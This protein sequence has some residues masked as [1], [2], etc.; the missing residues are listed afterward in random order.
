MWHSCVDSQLLRYSRDCAQALLG[1]EAPQALA[2]SQRA[3]QQAATAVALLGRPRGD[4]IVSSAW[5]HAIGESPSI[6][7]TGFRP[8]D[9]AVYLL[10]EG[11]PTPVVNLVAHQGQARLIAPAFDAV[12]RLALF[13]RIQGWPSDILD[14]AI[15]LSL[16][17]DMDPNPE[18]CL[19]LAAK[20]M[21]ATLRITARDRA[22]R[23]RRLRR[24]VDRVSAATIAARS[25]AHSAT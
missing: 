24:A 10:A 13:E 22:E 5:L 4:V 1:S 12:K 16:P 3:A 15:T 17:D 19:R 6:R 20:E 18:A 8:V 23:E 7:T 21:P 11:W 9:G 14:Y 25:P 2:R